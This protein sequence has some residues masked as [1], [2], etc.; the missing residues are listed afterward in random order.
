MRIATGATLSYPPGW[1]LTRGD[2]GTA[3]AVTLDAGRRIAGYLNLTPRQGAE[4]LRSW[5]GF[6]IAHNREEGA[7]DVRREAARAGVHF[8][9]GIGSCV[10]DSYTTVTHARYVEIACLVRG[11]GGGSVVVAASPPGQFGRL[12]P[13]LDRAISALTS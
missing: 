8:R 13:Q 11:A 10:R 6:R 2:R 4:T 9:T 7:R 3:T 5:S 12:L 1:R